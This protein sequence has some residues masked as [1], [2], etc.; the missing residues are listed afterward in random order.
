MDTFHAVCR[1]V[2]SVR[3]YRMAIY[4]TIEFIHG[5]SLEKILLS[6]FPCVHELSE[7]INKPSVKKISR[8]TPKI[9]LIKEA[10]L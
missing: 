6:K 2:E 1:F 7:V 9:W 5:E 3:W 8:K 4:V 10:A